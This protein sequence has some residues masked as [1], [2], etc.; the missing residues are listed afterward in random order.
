MASCCWALALLLLTALQP[1]V[2]AAPTVIARSK[3]F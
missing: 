1:S 2:A 3:V